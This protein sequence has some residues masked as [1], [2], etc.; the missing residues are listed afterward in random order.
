MEF[1]GWISFGPRKLWFHILLLAYWV[2]VKVRTLGIAPLRESSPQKRSGVARVLKGSHGFTC[3]Y[4]RTLMSHTFI[5]LLS[6]SWNSFTDPEGWKAELAWVPGYVV[7]QFTCP[8]AVTHPSTNQAYLLFT[9]LLLLTFSLYKAPPGEAISGPLMAL[10]L[11]TYSLLTYFLLTFSLYTAP[12]GEAINGPPGPLMAP[13]LL[14]YSLL[15]YFL[16]SF[17]LYKAPSGEVIDGRSFTYLPESW[18][19]YVYVPFV[20]KGNQIKPD[21]LSTKNSKRREFCAKHDGYGDFCDGLC[22]STTLQLDLR[23]KSSSRDICNSPQTP[24]SSSSNS[25]SSSCCSSSTSGPFL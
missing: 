15:A 24:C 16:L 11:L 23:Q 8:K 1:S 25:S 22:T 2:K 4:T 9:Y 10:H 12:S 20:V 19:I 6:Y 18:F 14:T 13:H 21:P 17:S 7:R 5:C 3:T